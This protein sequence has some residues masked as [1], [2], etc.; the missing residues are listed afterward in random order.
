MTDKAMM[1]MM[2]R[3]E[4][5]LR[6]LMGEEEFHKFSVELAKEAFRKEI[7]SM[8]DSEFKRFVTANFGA[9]TADGCDINELAEKYGNVT[10][11]EDA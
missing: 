8:E 6:E 3:M 9:I 10:G 4:D 1:H 5:K 2:K 7:D 11:S